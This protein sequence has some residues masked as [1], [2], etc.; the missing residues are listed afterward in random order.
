MAEVNS[1]KWTQKWRGDSRTYP[2][3]DYGLVWAWLHLS[4][5]G[6]YAR[7]HMKCMRELV[8]NGPGDGAARPLPKSGSCVANDCGRSGNGTRP[9]TVRTC[10]TILLPSSYRSRTSA[11]AQACLTC[12]TQHAMRADLWY[13]APLWPSRTRCCTDIKLESARSRRCAAIPHTASTL[14]NTD[15]SQSFGTHA[16]ERAWFA[17]V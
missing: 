7:S 4:S 14:Q 15:P 5:G 2:G 13:V 9:C 11:D 1:S 8:C 17:Q 3:P 12:V 6:G 16:P 10:Q